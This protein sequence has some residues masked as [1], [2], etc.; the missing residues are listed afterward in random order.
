MHSL[1]LNKYIAVVKGRDGFFLV[2]RNDVYIGKA[3]EI[4]G[5]YCGIEGDLLTS[6]IKPGQTVIEVGAN[7]GSHTVGLAKCVGST[8]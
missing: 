4:Y 1:L 2:N 3:L 8:G 5:E 6:L 7:I